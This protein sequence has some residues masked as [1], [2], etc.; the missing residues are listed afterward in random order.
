[1]H[2]LYVAHHIW[3]VNYNEKCIFAVLMDKDENINNWDEILESFVTNYRYLGFTYFD[4]PNTK[5][6]IR[7]TACD[8]TI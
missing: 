4:F 3:N 6:Q 8:N 5:L 1:M 2:Y 7:Y